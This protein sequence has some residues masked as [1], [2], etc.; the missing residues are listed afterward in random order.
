ML[1]S[2]ENAVANNE[3]NHA[4]P[5]FV[6]SYEDSEKSCKRRK[7]LYQCAKENCLIKHIQRLGTD[8]KSKK[9]KVIE[10]SSK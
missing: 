1:K 9:I 2:N 3:D 4:D 5:D 10:E 7:N 8:I 6:K